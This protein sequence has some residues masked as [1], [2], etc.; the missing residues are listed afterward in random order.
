[1]KKLIILAA[2][3]TVAVAYADVPKIYRITQQNISDLERKGVIS[4]ITEDIVAN[5]ET[6]LGY[7]STVIFDG[8]SFVGSGTVDLNYSTI[9]AAPYTIFNG[10]EVKGSLSNDRVQ[11]VWF[12]RYG[13]DA[14]GA[15]NRALKVAYESI[16]EIGGAT[17]SLR[18]PIVMNKNGQRISCTGTLRVINDISAIELSADNLDVNIHN[19]EGPGAG[20]ALKIKRA[21]TSNVSADRITG[22]DCAIDMTP[23][24]T[25]G[26]NSVQFNKI[27]IGRVEADTAIVI[28]PKANADI[29]GN[30]INIVSVT[31]NCGIFMK[32]SNDGQRHVY[33]NVFSGMSFEGLEKPLYITGSSSDRFYDIKF[34]EN[35]ISRSSSLISLSDTEHTEIRILGK[36]PISKIMNGCDLYHVI[37]D[38]IPTLDD[39]RTI[40]MAD[41]IVIYSEGDGGSG[42]ST[43]YLTK[44]TV[45]TNMLNELT[46]NTDKTIT[47]ADLMADMRLSRD[48]AKSL[49]YT[50]YQRMICNLT[51]IKVTKGAKLTIDLNGEPY[52]VNDPIVVRLDCAAGTC[53]LKDSAGKT[54]ELTSGTYRLTTDS[55]GICRLEKL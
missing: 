1:M 17:Y 37:I 50:F 15:I 7:A 55:D 4:I 33:E 42:A 38:G 40:E 25:L 36:Y 41:C 44:S 47:A 27:N 29:T 2:M 18:N 6:T 46:F 49:K 26:Y 24:A 31:G 23:S 8:G 9:Q 12:G 21:S 52:T 35:T 19:F 3:A 16:V 51:T 10:V 48:P 13:N 54:S 28:N 5:N 45:A 11:A 20:T 32:P 14:S 22:F 39:D 30:N 53:Q 34:D 43:M